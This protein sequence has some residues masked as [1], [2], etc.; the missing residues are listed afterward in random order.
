VAE[1]ADQERPQQMVRN[2]KDGTILA[3][4]PAGLFIAGDEKF[5]VELPAYYMGTT[6]VIN[7]Q[8]KQFVDA[9]G[10]RPP[11]KSQWG[12]PVWQG[13]SFPTEMADH[14]VVCVSWEDAQAYCEWAGVRLPSELEWEKAARGTD[15]R[16]YPWGNE[17]DPA[18]CCGQHDH[19]TGMTDTV[20]SCYEGRSPWG[21]YHMSGN[22]WEWCEDWFEEDAYL[23]YQKGEREP[24]S[25][26]ESRVLRGGSWV[27]DSV[28]VFRCTYRRCS[29]PDHRLFNLGF[30]VAKSEST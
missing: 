2:E 24:P 1:A 27:N 26:G 22:V 7:A 28:D 11:D 20:S 3:P 10:H 21:L 9:T 23:R 15:G 25:S 12:R 8:Y 13:T 17:W 4:I 30:R 19:A 29:H 16:Q 6:P 14:P 5:E 18:K